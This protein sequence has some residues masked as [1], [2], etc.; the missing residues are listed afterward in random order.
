[1]SKFETALSPLAFNNQLKGW[2]LHFSS[3]SLNTILL[4]PEKN[5]HV[6]VGN[7][8]WSVS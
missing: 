3:H 5:L 2:E 6:D 4:Y 1:M 8:L 7:F